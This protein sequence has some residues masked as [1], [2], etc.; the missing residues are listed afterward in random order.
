MK[1]KRT[2]VRQ[3]R[4]FEESKILC[5][6]HVTKSNH[7]SI[8]RKN[9]VFSLDIQRHSAGIANVIAHGTCPN[10]DTLAI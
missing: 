5:E 2:R 10:N 4:G 8:G 9:E 3:S 7:Q 1:I 6:V